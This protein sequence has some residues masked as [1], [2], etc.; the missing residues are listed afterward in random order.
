MRSRY[1][2]ISQILL[3]HV[4]LDMVFQHSN[5]NP[6]TRQ[7]GIAVTGLTVSFWKNRKGFGGILE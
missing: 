6:K 3:P 5:T 7:W 1:G 4:T 2:K